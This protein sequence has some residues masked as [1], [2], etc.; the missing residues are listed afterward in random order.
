MRQMVWSVLMITVGIFIAGE[1]NTH[2]A[3]ATNASLTVDVLDTGRPHVVLTKSGMP[4]QKQKRDDNEGCQVIP[5]GKLNEHKSQEQDH[6]IM[7]GL[8]F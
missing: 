1:W 4:Q 2:T 3:V 6:S 8:V 5:N 7:K